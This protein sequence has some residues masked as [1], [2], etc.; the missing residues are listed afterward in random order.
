LEQEENDLIMYNDQLSA[1]HIHQSILHNPD[2]AKLGSVE[3]PESIRVTGTNIKQG[4]VPSQ[5]GAAAIRYS[6]GDQGKASGRN[7]TCLHDLGVLRQNRT[8]QRSIEAHRKDQA[9]SP[10]KFSD[11]GNEHKLP[12]K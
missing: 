9:L 11:E 7:T 1:R 3:D 10:M 5:V 4:G 2:E 12:N 8:S 6:L